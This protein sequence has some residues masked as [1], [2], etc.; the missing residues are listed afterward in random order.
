MVVLTVAFAVQCFN[1]VYI[2]STVE[3]W[4]PLTPFALAA[5]TSGNC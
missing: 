5:D 2:R 1:D 3:N 4:L